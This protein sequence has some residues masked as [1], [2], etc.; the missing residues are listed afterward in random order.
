M[1]P[2][3]LAAELRPLRIKSYLDWNGA[4]PAR[5]YRYQDFLEPWERSLSAACLPVAVFNQL[6]SLDLT[7]QSV[8]N[9][10]SVR[11]IASNGA[12]PNTLTL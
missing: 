7:L 10:A 1:T 12:G 5:G 6:E 3:A 8:R 11:E 2:H 9:L 4:D